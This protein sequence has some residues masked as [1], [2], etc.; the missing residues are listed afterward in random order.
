[1]LLLLSPIPGMISASWIWCKLTGEVFAYPFLQWWSATQWWSANW[2]C[3]VC[4]VAGAAPSALAICV[5]TFVAGILWMTKKP[6]S[7]GPAVYGRTE[8]AT[9]QQMNAG[10]ISSSGNPFN[11]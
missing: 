6:A 2:W 4:L 8:F 10:K 5:L 1:M 7:T 9:E 11:A 3:K